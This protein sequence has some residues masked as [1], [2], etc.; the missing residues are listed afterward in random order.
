LLTNV[1]KTK[2]SRPLF[3]GLIFVVVI[4]IFMSLNFSGQQDHSDTSEQ[5]LAKIL[6]E[7]EGVGQVFVYFHYEQ[8]KQQQF[9]AVTQQPTISGVMI[10]AQG[11]QDVKV[12]L[13]VKQAVGNVLQIP[14]HRIQVVAMQQKEEAK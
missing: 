8:Q 13:L 12:Q 10:V 6:S 1:E 7:M 2:A 11:A 3:I 5:Q 4:G 9:L 14:M